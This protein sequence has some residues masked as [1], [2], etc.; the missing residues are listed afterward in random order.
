MNKIANIKTLTHQEEIELLRQAKEG[1]TRQERA[2]ATRLLIYYN[3]SF[4]KYLVGG[5][6]YNEINSEDLV[7]EGS[8]G[9]LQAI[10]E[11]DLSRAEKYRLATAQKKPEFIEEE[12]VDSLEEEKKL[13]P[14]SEQQVEQQIQYEEN[15]IKV[16]ELISHL[17]YHEELIIRLFFGITPANLKQISRLATDEK[18]K[19]LKR[20]KMKKNT[21]SGEEKPHPLLEKYREILTVPR[22]KEEVVPEFM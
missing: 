11:F 3:R 9:L 2:K 15:K 5:Y 19:E 1:K 20:I 22:K 10:K 21:L 12:E 18:V 4:V 8:I 16:N 7:A 13:P 17:A 14:K 6:Y